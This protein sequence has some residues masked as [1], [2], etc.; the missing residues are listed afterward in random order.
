LGDIRNDTDA[1]CTYE[2]E[3]NVLQQQAANY[4]LQVWARRK[5]G[6]V[7]SPFG[8]VDFM[9]NWE[10]IQQTKFPARIVEKAV[11]PESNI[12]IFINFYFEKILIFVQPCW[13]LMNG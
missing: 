4:L 2:G 7:S 5:E 11:A 9:T 1:N 13:H 3:N 8:S 10:K 6:P 12:F